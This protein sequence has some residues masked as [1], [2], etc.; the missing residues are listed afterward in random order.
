MK[1]EM[2][3]IVMQKIRLKKK[4]NMMKMRQKYSSRK[5]KALDEKYEK[6]TVV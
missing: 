4:K 3:N 6:N 2:K 1:N 5:N